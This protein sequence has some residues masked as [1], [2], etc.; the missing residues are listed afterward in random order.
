[1]KKNCVN[2]LVLVMGCIFVVRLLI[3][4]NISVAKIALRQPACFWRVSN[5][6]GKTYPFFQ[7]WNNRFHLKFWCHKICSTKF[8][9][10]DPKTN[11]TQWNLATHVSWKILYLSYDFLGILRSGSTALELPSLIQLEN[12]EK[13]LNIEAYWNTFKVGIGKGIKMLKLGPM[14][15]NLNLKFGDNMGIMIWSFAIDKNTK[16]WK[17][18]KI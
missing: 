9:E 12:G 11:L 2:P 1:M 17:F 4:N 13:E 10:V 18:L 3:N 15:N 16:D 14:K 7:L 6:G 8:W 5:L